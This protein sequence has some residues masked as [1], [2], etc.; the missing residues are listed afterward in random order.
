VTSTSKALFLLGKTV[1]T[2]GAIEALNTEGVSARELLE[3][4]VGGDWGDLSEDDRSENEL[5]VKEGFRI[6]SAYTLP[7]TGVRLW[8]ITEADRSVTTLLLPD[9]Y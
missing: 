5:S 8:I 9:E 6:L 3:R 7:R 1:A 4:H 2:P